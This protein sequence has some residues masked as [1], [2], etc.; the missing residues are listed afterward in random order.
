MNQRS[1]IVQGHDGLTSVTYRIVRIDYGNDRLANFVVERQASWNAMEEPNW[2][3]VDPSTV[4]R[5]ILGLIDKLLGDLFLSGDS[6]ALVDE[7][8][9]AVQLLNRTK[10][11][12]EPTTP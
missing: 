2:E 10:A 5:V 4:V 11:K 7:V 6:A 12:T 8:I 1:I 9:G 3:G